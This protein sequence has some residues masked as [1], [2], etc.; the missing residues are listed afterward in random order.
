MVLV[1][2]AMLFAA[3]YPIS[4]RKLLTAAGYFYTIG[5]VAAGMG[6]ASAYLFGTGDA[7]AFTLGTLVSILAILLIAELG[8][9]SSTNGWCGLCTESQ[10]RSPVTGRKSK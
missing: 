3:F 2:A 7:P 1:S 10:W 8:W 4:W 6:L 9:G 5:F